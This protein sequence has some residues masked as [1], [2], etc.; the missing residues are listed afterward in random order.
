[1]FSSSEIS[2]STLTSLASDENVFED[3]ATERTRTKPKRSNAMR[4]KKNLNISFDSLQKSD[5]NLAD[6]ENDLSGDEN[7]STDSKNVDKEK[8]AQLLVPVVPAEVQLD[9]RQLLHQV[10]P[11][12]A[13]LVP[14]AVQL[15]P[16]VLDHQQ[17][18]DML[19]PVTNQ[20]ANNE[21][22]GA[23][24][25]RRSTRLEIDYKK[26]NQTGETN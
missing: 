19:H 6:D 21:T 7:P 8:A 11:L 16:G 5:D 4:R 22:Q 1:M 17:A 10:L 3:G 23:A 12:R 26:Y 14:E 15:G 2:D 13:P 25:P 20:P 9:R 24:R 18:L